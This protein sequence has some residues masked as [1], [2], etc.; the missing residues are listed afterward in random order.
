MSI[1]FGLG[2]TLPVGNTIGECP[3]WDDR[4]ETVYWTDISSRR[5]WSWQFGGENPASY[6]LPENLASMALTGTPGVFIGAFEKGFARFDPACGSLE[7]VV[8]IE[9][10]QRHLVM[11]DGRVDRAGNFWSSTKLVGEKPASGPGG[12][13]WRLDGPGR[14]MPF[15]GG[16]EV[17]NGLAF[18]GDGRSMFLADS[19]KAAIWKFALDREDGP[20]GCALFAQTAPGVKPDGACIDAEDRYWSAHWG[21][22]AVVCYDTD[23][24]IVAQ[25]DLP[26][27]QPSCVAFGGPQLDH[28]IVTSAREG[29]APEALAREPLAGSLFVYRTNV[30]GRREDRCTGDFAQAMAA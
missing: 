20:I 17:P 14:A 10:R 28:L 18:T 27:S 9:I 16:L 23:G 22:G 13:L 2:H 21:G 6:A 25:L 19:E 15:L 29:L 30:R 7:R 4:T 1:A 11:N 3:L 8:D 5:F 26:V 12:K 24:T